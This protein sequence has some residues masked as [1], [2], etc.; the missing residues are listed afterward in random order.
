MHTYNCGLIQRCLP[1]CALRWLQC[2]MS[3][4]DADMYDV[5][6]VGQP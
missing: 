3:E 5:L 2:E 4:E 6:K 1:V